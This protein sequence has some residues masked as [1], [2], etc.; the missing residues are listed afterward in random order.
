MTFTKSD[1]FAEIGVDSRPDSEMTRDE[2]IA[3]NLKV[4]D[5]HFHSETPESVEKAVA[6]YA[7]DITWEA[8]ARGVV[9]KDPKEVLAAY[10]DIFRT[11]AYRKTLTLRRFATEKFVF[12]DQ[13]AHAHVVGDP[14]L[15]PNMP[16][17]KGTEI[18]ARL[19]HCFQMRDGLIAR[20]IVYELW[21][22]LGSEVARDDVPEDAVWEIYSELPE[23]V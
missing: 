13:V 10:R 1:A 11:L 9:M 12:D 20:E 16:Y 22:V 3:R 5:Y 4:V 23:T 7:D 6:V 21:R 17:P 19:V 14:A 2:I 8:P 15:M 18:H